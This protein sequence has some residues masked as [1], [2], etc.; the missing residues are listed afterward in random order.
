MEVKDAEFLRRLVETKG[1]TARQLARQMGWASHS[2]LNRILRGEVRTMTPDAAVKLAYLLQVPVDLV[3][4][5]RV[6]SETRQTE[7]RKSA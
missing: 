4:V 7:G 6:S 3:F 2:Y 5:H 1:L